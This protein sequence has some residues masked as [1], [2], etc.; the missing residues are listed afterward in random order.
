M[1]NSWIHGQ[2]QQQQ[3]QQHQQQQQQQHSKVILFNHS[4]KSIITPAKIHSP[5]VI[6]TI[7]LEKGDKT[8]PLGYLNGTICT[9]H[10]EIWTSLI[11][12]FDKLE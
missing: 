3:Q 9:F 1:L 10:K 12:K 4:N 11:T 6:I 5:V 7:I 8:V 2:Q